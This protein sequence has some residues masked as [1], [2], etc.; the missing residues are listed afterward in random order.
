MV[1]KNTESYNSMG[2]IVK[3]MWVMNKTT[4]VENITFVLRAK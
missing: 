4:G 2:A 3:R 1:S